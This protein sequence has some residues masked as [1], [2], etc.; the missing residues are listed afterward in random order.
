M[1]RVLTQEQA[2]ESLLDGR[3]SLVDTRSAPEFSRGHPAGA[4][5]VPYSE[6]GFAT[7]IRVVEP[8]VA[9]VIV[10]GLTE[11]E[12]SGAVRQL[13]ESGITMMGQAPAEGVWWAEVGVGWQVL[14]E[15]SIDGL[16]GTGETVVIDVREPMEWE[17][18][19]VPSAVL[20]PLSE[21]HER[22][23]AI[24][25]GEDT[26]V[27]LICETGIRSATAASI[28]QK[29]GYTNVAHAPQGTAGIR[30]DGG[31]LEYPQATAMEAT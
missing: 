24:P 25:R 4:L 1:T 8:D 21:L 23:D 7:R 16:A 26:D 30:R 10:V 13:G 2:R 3:T 15:R 6:R 11:G 29:A 27:V 20:I 18:G 22:A 31:A 28:L 12:L 19:H 14:P 17:T 9:A 5:C